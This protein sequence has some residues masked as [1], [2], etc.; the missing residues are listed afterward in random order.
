MRADLSKFRSRFAL[1]RENGHVL[2]NV[3]SYY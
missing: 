3:M 1:W 2:K